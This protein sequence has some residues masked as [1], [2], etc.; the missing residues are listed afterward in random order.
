MMDVIKNGKL[1]DAELQAE[2][3]DILNQAIEEVKK[4]F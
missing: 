4:E 2:L 1:D 3:Q